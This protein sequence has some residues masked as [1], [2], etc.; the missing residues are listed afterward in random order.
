MQLFDA[1]LHIINKAFSIKANAG[2]IPEAFTVK[3]YLHQMKDYNLTGGA[4]VSGSFQGFDQNYLIAAL[5]LLGPTFVGVTQLPASVTD[6]EILALNKLGVRALR[7][8]LKRGGSATLRELDRLAHRVYEVAGWHSE[9][10]V[11]SVELA[12]Q[13]SLSQPLASILV[14]LPAVSIDHLGLSKAGLPSLLLLVEQGVRVKAT[15]F[16]RVDFDIPTALRNLHSANPSALMFGSDLPS[17]RAPRPFCH[18]DITTIIDCLGVEAA[19]AVLH[20]NAVAFYK[21]YSL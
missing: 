13:Q 1:H 21:P 12:L 3:Q 20:A 9:L 4:I 2:F 17:T 7:F 10:Y 15:G 18:N 19:S 16:G 14:N 6:N 11:D 8:N 5:K